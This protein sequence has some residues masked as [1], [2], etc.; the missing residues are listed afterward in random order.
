MIY[1]FIIQSDSNEPLYRKIYLGIRSA[2]TNG[3]LK[4]GE[5]LPSIRKISRDL[6]VSKTTVEAAY[7]QLCAEGYIKSIPQSGF[8]VDAEFGNISEKNSDT[9][10]RTAIKKKV[11]EYDFGSKSAD[12]GNF[13]SWRKYVKDVLNKPYLL[14]S[15]GDVNGEPALREALQRYAFAVRG[16]HTD[17]ESIIIGA[18]TQYLLYLLCGRL[19]DK[20]TIALE[21]DSYPYAE[22][23]FEDMGFKVIYAQSDEFGI[24]PRSL[25]ISKPDIVLVNPNQTYKSGNI[26]PVQRRID[27]INYAK[28]NKA[29]IIE[30]DYN[31]ELRYKSRPVPAIQSYDKAHVVYLG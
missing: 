10:K 27:I 19:K 6:N 26:M 20:K 24:I 17:S 21:S 11:Y 1:D 3:K 23:I 22:Q 25:E 28:E 5:K 16:V 13:T 15:Y 30:D 2:I 4:K 29:V 7:N 18:G 14:S 9:D 12:L 31:G 8:R